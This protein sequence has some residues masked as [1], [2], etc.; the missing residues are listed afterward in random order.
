M[1][2]T[3]QKSVQNRIIKYAKGTGWRYVA[4]KG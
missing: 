2:P 3:E 4:R 1:K